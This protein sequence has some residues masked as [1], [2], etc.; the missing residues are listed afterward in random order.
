MK[1]TPRP[2]AKTPLCPVCVGEARLLASIVGQD[3]R[4]YDAFAC[5]ACDLRFVRP[6]DGAWSVHFDDLYSE[7]FYDAMAPSVEE[8]WRREKGVVEAQLRFLRRYISRPG[9]AL[10]VGAGNGI[11]M[12]LLQ[13]AGWEV[14]GTEVSQPAIASARERWGLDIHLGLVEEAPFAEESFDFIQMRHVVEHLVDPKRTL[15]QVVR[16]LKPGGI[17]KVDTTTRGWSDRAHWWMEQGLLPW[18]TRRRP[19]DPGL[20]NLDPPEHNFWY[21][22]EALRLLLQGAGLSVPRLIRPY[23]GHPH[24]YPSLR[25]LKGHNWKGSL[26]Y[27][28]V[29][30][31]DVAASQINKGSVL[32]AYAKKPAS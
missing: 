17:L 14:S 8:R 24:H 13:D 21:S 25:H 18:L 20:G 11:H 15:H 4:L 22:E 23:H 28:L 12:R 5:T 3:Q 27:L 29:Y 26:E 32:V 31:V 10:D 9:R 16:L 1:P 6:A 2:E 7:E 19:A 30:L